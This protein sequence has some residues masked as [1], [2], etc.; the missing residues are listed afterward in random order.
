M[1]IEM[2]EWISLNAQYVKKLV[3]SKG[4]EEMD[5]LKKLWAAHPELHPDTGD[6]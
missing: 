3:T 1:E 6:I 5:M 4:M 2:D